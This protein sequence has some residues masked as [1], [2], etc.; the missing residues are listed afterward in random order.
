MWNYVQEITR[1]LVTLA[2][3]TSYLAFITSKFEVVVVSLLLLIFVHL[4]NRAA[5]LAAKADYFAFCH[6][7]GIN[8]IR[9]AIPNSKCE[10]DSE[11]EARLMAR[12]EKASKGELIQSR[13]D[14][15]IF[16]VLLLIVAGKLLVTLL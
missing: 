13:I 4:D 10:Y 5:F 3:L 11:G 7:K 16:F 15:A 2:L 6:T 9:Q 1:Y 12:M 8:L 14:N